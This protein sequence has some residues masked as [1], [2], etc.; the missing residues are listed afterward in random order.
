MSKKLTSEQPIRAEHSN[1]F[2]QFFRRFGV[3]LHQEASYLWFVYDQ[4]WWAMTHTFLTWSRRINAQISIWNGTWNHGSSLYWGTTS[5][6]NRRRTNFY[7]FEERSRLFS[8]LARTHTHT[9]HSISFC[10]R[11]NLMSVL[12]PVLSCQQIR[13]AV[14]RE[15]LF[16]VFIMFWYLCVSLTNIR[17]DD[18]R[19]WF[20]IYSKYLETNIH[21]ANGNGIYCRSNDGKRVCLCHCRSS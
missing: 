15:N 7:T 19:L 21:G 9:Q 17:L 10:T 4:Y 18:K 1:G 2:P 5:L 12:T 11:R 20:K 14:E 3:K 8:C 13:R 16:F 6:H